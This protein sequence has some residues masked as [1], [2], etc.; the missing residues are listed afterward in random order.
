MLAEMKNG[1]FMIA[2]FPISYVLI[3]HSFTS[4]VS[5]TVQNIVELGETISMSRW[6]FRKYQR[7][8]DKKDRNKKR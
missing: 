6:T 3:S 4:F 8:I 2:W 7:D 5:S 1:V